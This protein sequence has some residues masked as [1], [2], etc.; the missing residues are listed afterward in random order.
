MEKQTAQQI[1]EIRR[2]MDKN[3]LL[4]VLGELGGLFNRSGKKL[5][6]RTPRKLFSTWLKGANLFFLPL[7]TNEPLKAFGFRNHNS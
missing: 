6:P 1:A 5:P 3:F 4:G 2:K 7:E